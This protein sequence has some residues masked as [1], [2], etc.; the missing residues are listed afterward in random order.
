MDGNCMKDRRIKKSSPWNKGLKGIYHIWGGKRVFSE[1]HIENIRKSSKKRLLGKTYEEIYGPEK[2]KELREK[3]RIQ[4]K[5]RIWSIETRRR[6]GE[7]N[8]KKAMERGDRKMLLSKEELHDLY[9]N[10]KKSLREI[11]N[12]LGMKSISVVHRWF[13]KF[14]IERRTK[15]EEMKLR[16]KDPHYRRSM[17]EG[18]KRALQKPEN[19]AKWSENSK[20]RWKNKDYAEHIIR[21]TRRSMMLRP[22]KP[23]QRLIAI[24]KKHDLP[25]KYSGDGRFIVGNRCPDFLNCNGEKKVV[26]VF[27]RAYHSP[28][29][30]FFKIPYRRTYQGTIDHYKKYGFECIIIWDDELGD[31]NKVLERLYGRF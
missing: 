6:I 20:R 21:E 4:G 23:E 2:A 17:I 3:K 8:A 10:Q 25:Y 5:G 16:W 22:N 15:Q 9:W 12:I 13:K 19:R 1:D 14:G 30:S 28:S 26:E 27:G 29:H 7:T 24:I 11:C 31:E 18:Q